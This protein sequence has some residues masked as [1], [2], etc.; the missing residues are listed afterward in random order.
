MF[1]THTI[2]QSQIK[3]MAAALSRGQTGLQSLGGMLNFPVEINF[4]SV[5]YPFNVSPLGPGFYRLKINDQLID[6][7]VREQ[8]DKSLLCTV[9]VCRTVYAHT[10]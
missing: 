7:R 1:R 5:K 2:V 8:P 6:A 9:G 10:A 4:D 3:E